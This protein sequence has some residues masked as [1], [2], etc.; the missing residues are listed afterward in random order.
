MDKKKLNESKTDVIASVLSATVSNIPIVG[1]FGSE[2]ISRL[3]P[4]QRMDRV[5][6][7]IS[8]LSD[9]LDKLKVSVDD[10]KH[11]YS[12][13]SYGAF[14][15]RC[16]NNVVNEVYE[17]KIKYYKK[18]CVDGLTNEEKELYQTERVLKIFSDMDYYEVLYLKFYYYSLYINYDK[19]EQIQKELGFISLKPM[20]SFDMEQDKIDNETYKQITLNN[21]V[22][23]GLLNIDVKGTNKIKQENYKITQLGILIL[24]K[25]GVIENE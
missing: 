3:I 4:N 20:Y 17:E 7:F 1:S 24:K 21:L 5:V 12:N 6:N 19:L 23:K 18:L 11:I 8:D 9:E 22:N 13:Y 15:Y 25:I 14:T 10:L 16:L 2:I